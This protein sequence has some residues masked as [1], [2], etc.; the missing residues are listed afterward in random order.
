MPEYELVIRSPDGAVL[1][2]LVQVALKRGLQPT[3]RPISEPARES[4]GIDAAPTKQRAGRQGS[5]S[6]PSWDA[7]LRY[8]SPGQIEVLRA[9][10]ALRAPASA[11]N[12]AQQLGIS[13][14]QFT[15]RLNGGLQKNIRKAGFQVPDVI[16]IH[17]DGPVI[18]YTSGDILYRN[19]V[20]AGGAP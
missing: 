7:F 12:I 6:V 15:G 20:P 3:F 8:C 19:D 5:P 1:A 17:E 9:I 2:E 4:S 10:K 11:A 16:V 18:T 14:N 13:T